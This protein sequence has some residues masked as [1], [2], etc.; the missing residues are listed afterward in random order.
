MDERRFRSVLDSLLEPRMT[1]RLQLASLNV[2]LAYS[3]QAKC[4]PFSTSSGNMLLASLARCLS[5]C[6][7]QGAVRPATDAMAARAPPRRAISAVIAHL[8]RMSQST[9]AWLCLLQ[10]RDYA[11]EHAMPG[12]TVATFRQLG[13]VRSVLRCSKYAKCTQLLASTQDFA[14]IESWHHPI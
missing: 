8:H 7:F 1:W 11:A 3:E 12:L 4:G 10:A 9:T 2:H 6:R 14:D 5:S 13:M